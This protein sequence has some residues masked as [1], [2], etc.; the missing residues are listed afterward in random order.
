MISCAEWP[1]TIFALLFNF[2]LKPSIAGSLIAKK[3]N[4]ENKP[5]TIEAIIN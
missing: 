3:K 4:I 1:A 2:F 5:I